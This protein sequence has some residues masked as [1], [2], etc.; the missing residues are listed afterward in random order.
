MELNTEVINKL[1]DRI[2][3]CEQV[4]PPD[5]EWGRVGP[6]FTMRQI[7]Y[8]CGSPA[9]IIGHNAALHG[10]NVPPLITNLEVVADL[11]ITEDQSEELTAPQHRDYAD[12][13]AHP[14]DPGFITKDHAVAVLRHLADTGEVEWMIGA[15][16]DPAA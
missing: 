10:R 8:R 7:S 13:W 5:H 15:A 1:A 6:A 9:C 14:G 4:D 11:G 16:D 3:K 2:E 12:Y